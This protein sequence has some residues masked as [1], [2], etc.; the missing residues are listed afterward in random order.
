MSLPRHLR[1]IV[2]HG[3]STRLKYAHD[4]EA[5]GKG[6][7]RTSFL[8]AGDGGRRRYST[9][10]RE[11]DFLVSPNAGNRPSQVP[12]G[13]NLRQHRQFLRE[14]RAERAISPDG[15]IWPMLT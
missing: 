9:F 8:V 4:L 11:R 6:R 14:S 5:W 10:D 15:N 2:S 1:K 13:P 12:P 3:I 7:T